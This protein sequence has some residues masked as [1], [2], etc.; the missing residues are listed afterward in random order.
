MPRET[1]TPLD[2]PLGPFRLE[3]R[4][5]F[6]DASV[7][8]GLGAFVHRWAKTTCAALTDPRLRASLGRMAEA[9]G[10][11]ALLGPD[12]RRDLI[13]RGRKMVELLQRAAPT[14]SAEKLRP[15]PKPDVAWA[16]PVSSLRGVGPAREKLLEAMGIGSVADLLQHYPM[17]HEDRR[18]MQHAN[19]FHHR[20]SGCIACT[21][22]GPGEVLRRAG[23]TV[24]EVPARDDGGDFVLAWFNQ[25]FRATQFDPGTAMIVT[26][27]AHRSQ[28]GTMLIVA[29]VELI[30][31]D[32]P[33]H[34]G[35]IVPIY[36]LTKGL[37]QSTLRRLVSEA[38]EKCPDIPVDRVPSGI[39]E[40]RKLA[41]FRWALQNIHFPA[42]N[43]A[44]SL[45]RERIA[46][47]ELFLLQ[48]KLALRRLRDRDQ[49][50]GR[51]LCTD[52]CI[53]AL[54]ENL[55][56]ILTRAQERVIGEVLADLSGAHPAHRL[57]HGDVG[58]GKTVVAAAAMIA[59][60]RNGTQ[61]ALMAPTEL[62]AEQHH[63]TLTRLL[64]PFGLEPVLLTGSMSGAERRAALDA[65]RSGSCP[66]AVGTHALF[67]DAVRFAD[68]SVA[69]VDEQ[70]R[71]GV[72]QRASLAAKGTRP[73]VFVMSAT[74]IP[75][76]L[77][78]TAYG[79]YDVSVLDELPPGRMPVH[80]QLITRGD[81]RTAHEVIYEHVNR[82]HQAYIVCP[83]VDDGREAN[84][85]SAEEML[86]TLQAHV[87]P[88][89]R[90]GLVHGRIPVETRAATMQAFHRGDID[91]LVATTV[92]E[93]GVDVPNAVVMM[94]ENAERFGLAQLHQLRGRVGRGEEKALCL[95]VTSARSEDVVS[96]L[97][98]LERTTDGFRIAEE[99]MRRRGPGEMAGVRQSGIPDLRMADLLAD[100]KTLVAARED[101][102]ACISA[103][104]SLSRPETVALRG[105]LAAA[106]PRAAEWVL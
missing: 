21:V 93:V 103:D 40:K 22:T 45:A 90:V 34:S 100:T 24:V 31:D 36:P 74:P 78:L 76:T 8:G 94:I 32:A 30:R 63:L 55:P 105:Y 26:G 52:G 79:D 88:K 106:E 12:E 53:E 29:E 5:G 28:R 25:P 43:D 3:E 23:R 82:G 101:A 71:F 99:D 83:L 92:I 7:E 13:V 11:Y 58:S 38:L 15:A 17:R 19:D 69:I 70:H 10:K 81:R 20:Q 33:L 46:F 59:A 47:E 16:A 68:L 39:V 72:R 96:R 60:T 91:I 14:P 6:R 97:Q 67:Q 4:T 73:H 48:A 87:F 42:E 37:G 104:P 75:R 62:L 64:G 57:I 50:P 66:V 61:A 9:F 35:R 1:Q 86:A 2:L 51:I 54:Q 85:A 95:L 49:A 98:V 41:D 84:L 44:I 56:F 102:F 77:A 65:I 27:Q 89:L 18:Q 80:T